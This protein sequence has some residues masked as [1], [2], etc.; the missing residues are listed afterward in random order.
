MGV[1]GIQSPR[2]VINLRAD[3][4]FTGDG[5]FETPYVIVTE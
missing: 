3:V 4:E 2:P 1:H 5:S